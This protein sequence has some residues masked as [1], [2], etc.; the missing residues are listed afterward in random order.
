M[1]GWCPRTNTQSMCSK[2]TR[3]TY[4]ANVWVVLSV[5]RA[6]DVCRCEALCFASVWPVTC[7]HLKGVA[8]SPVSKTLCFRCPGPYVGLA[9]SYIYT[10]YDRI[11]GDFPAKN[12][13]CNPYTYGSG[14]PYALAISKKETDRAASAQ[15]HMC[16]VLTHAALVGLART[17]YIY[18]I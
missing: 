3:M 12:T 17:V 14:Q 18:R 5:V 4:V 2:R 15:E 8:Q 1:C 11:F 10:V 9:K 6:G 13:V 16:A 7:M